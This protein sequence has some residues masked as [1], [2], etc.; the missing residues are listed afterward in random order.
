MTSA[1]FGVDPDDPV[2]VT[3][4][5]HPVVLDVVDPAVL[6]VAHGVK[7]VPRVGRDQLK[8]ILLDRVLWYDDPPRRGCIWS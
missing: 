6:P 5:Q 1:S 4:D 2:V 3:V 7:A 8:G